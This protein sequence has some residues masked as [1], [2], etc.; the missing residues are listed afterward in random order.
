MRV[1]RLVHRGGD[2]CNSAAVFVPVPMVWAQKLDR[3]RDI[4]RILYCT[5][6]TVRVSLGWA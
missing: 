6:R 4:A 5:V 2:A 3:V 1:F